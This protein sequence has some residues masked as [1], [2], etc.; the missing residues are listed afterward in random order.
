[1]IMCIGL[2]LKWFS[3][4][5]KLNSYLPEKQGF[6][7]WQTSRNGCGSWQPAQFSINDC[8]RRMSA[9]WLAMSCCNFL[10]NAIKLLMPRSKFSKLNWKASSESTEKIFHVVNA[11]HHNRHAWLE[12]LHGRATHRYSYLYR[13]FDNIDSRHVSYFFRFLNGTMTNT[14]K[15]KRQCQKP[16]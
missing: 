14:K 1:M 13:P 2:W 9:C 8:R 11:H 16:L 4:K 15:N 3:I 12:Y 6:A 7:Y 5:C 10:I